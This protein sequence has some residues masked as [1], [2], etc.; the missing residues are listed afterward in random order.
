MFN[1][2]SWALRRPVT[3]ITLAVGL[4]LLG[5]VAARRMRVDIFPNLNLPVVYV[6]QPYGGMDPSQMEGLLTNYYEYHFLYINGIHHVESR[7]VQG[8]A[9]MKL[10]FHPGTDMA[11]AM[12]ETLGYVTRARAFM[13]PGT[14][15]PFV[16]RFDAGSIPVGYL[17]LSSET[18]T[19]NEIQ[20]IALFKV[21]PMFAG[22]PGV[23]AP[24]PFGGSQRTIV[25]QLDPDRLKSYRMAPDE[26]IK[27]LNSGNTISPSGTVRFGNTMPIVPVNALARTLDDFRQ[28][29]V[30]PGQLPT[31]HLGDVANVA[32]AADVP[33]G[34]AL[35]NGRKAVYLLVT[36]RADSSTLDVVNNVKNAL[37]EM[38]A[39]LPNDIKVSLEFDQSPTVTNAVRAVISEAIL[40]ALLVGLMVLLFLRDWR[41]ML[42]V[43]I[44]IPLALAGAIFLLWISGQSFNLMTLGGL[45]LAIGILVDES[46]VELENI[47]TQLRQT[48]S[49][50]VA[51]RR[52]NRETAVPR[53]LALLCMLAVFAPSF[54]MTGAIRALFV[55]LSMAVGYAM[56][57]SYLLSS[58]LVPVL[59]AY[60]MKP[61]GHTLG[62]ADFN[63]NPASDSPAPRPRLI[64]SFGLLTAYLA[65]AAF[66]IWKIVPRAGFEVF[67]QADSGRFQVRV[68]APA[69]TRFE[70]TE[71]IVVDVVNSVKKI[72]GDEGVEVSVGYVGNIGSSYPIQ[73]I[74]QW[75]GGP[76]EAF[77]RVALDPSRSKYSADQTKDLLRQELANLHPAVSF[78]FEPADIVSEVMSFGSPTPVEVV[79]TGSA[80]PDV[81]AYAAK[82]REELA[83]VN[84]IKDLRY[85]QTLDYPALRVDIDRR[86]AG[87]SG[88][89]AG[90]VARS[91]VTATSSSRFIMPS[92]W[93]DPKSGIGY[94]VQVEIPYASITSAEELA[95]LPINAGTDASPVVLRDVATVTPDQVPGEFDRYN[96]KRTVSLTANVATADLSIVSRDVAAAVKAAGQ[97]PT[98]VTVAVRGQLATLDELNKAGSLALLSTFVVIFLLLT[99][100]YQSSGLAMVALSGIPAV[101]LGITLALVLTSTTWNLQS[102]MGAIMALGVSVANAIILVSFAESQRLAGMDVVSAANSALRRRLRPILMTAL[103]MIAG[104]LPMALGLSEGGQQQAPLG[105]AVIGGL[106]GSLV[107]VVLVM[108]R[109]FAMIRARASHNNRSLDPADPNSPYY[110]PT[111][112]NPSQE[113]GSPMKN[114]LMAISLVLLYF[115]L[116]A[117]CVQAQDATAKA[118]APPKVSFVRAKPALIEHKI[119]QPGQVE[120]ALAAQIQS[121]AA[122]W[123]KTVHVDIGD[124]VKKGQKLIEI[125]APE[126]QAE[127]AISRAQIDEASAQVELAKSQYDEGV[128]TLKADQARLL[129]SNADLKG[130]QAILQQFQ[131]ELDRIK[132]LVNS[133]AVTRSNLEEAEQKY[134]SASA[135]LNESAAMESAARA[136]TDAVKAQL[137]RRKAD[138]SVAQARL[139]VA[140]AKAAETQARHDFMTIKAP[141][142]G[143]IV[144]RNTDPGQ[145]VGSSPTTLPLL[146]IH[147]LDL[148]T[149]TV[150]VPEAEAPL[151]DLGDT[152]EIYTSQNSAKPA[153]TGK[154]SRT[155]RAYN[156]ATRTLR[157]EIDVPAGQS[158]LNSGQYVLVRVIGHSVQEPVT[159]PVNAIYKVA[160]N[161]FCTIVSSGTA[162]RA[163]VSVGV[164]DGT[165]I[166]ISSGVKS[167]DMVIVGPAAA[168]LADGQ[169][170]DASELDETKK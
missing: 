110:D 114:P 56:M 11:Q 95:N 111:V 149:V 13:P 82:L 80:L 146:L 14:V 94:Q 157:T 128:E 117:Q 113:N 39:V 2:I 25:V 154:I 75:T 101:G 10:Y 118:S 115:P 27:A 120:P 46:T 47:H 42:I 57:C 52:G 40:G 34:S 103:A 31:I 16:T 90:D 58:T 38:Q 127:L 161:S 67:P 71:K 144:E 141:F 24:P 61:A 81:R 72:V 97:P 77:L 143:V 83:K 122:G 85:G 121:R 91:L 6:C 151:I 148:L 88:L 29:P 166:A 126:L 93:P 150:G 9:L 162:R 102:Y 140:Q 18:R 139:A 100:Y 147:K 55:P 12:A 32:D 49:V 1:P 66:G 73:A 43:I 37:P 105:R 44:N 134:L 167:G 86:R 70:V 54:L 99:A 74:F 62:Q 87:L 78:S 125:D 112:D 76:E 158:R 138:I 21:R 28:I 30:R 131:L 8:L 3:V 7:N 106:V 160:G 68:K 98:G 50:P 108:P 84:S 60:L 89:T 51:V 164:G 169:A 156:P 17:V 64:L 159:L 130:K 135:E 15:S 133:G 163:G 19:I 59:A 69:G 123:V 152:V 48:A 41:G 116:S 53:L 33:V 23:S 132:R 119:E 22:L 142:D 20:D 145:I 165:R 65:V 63:T 45:A 35:V 137:A 155:S 36:K 170:V 5:T 26:V 96:M 104:M 4:M 92:Y 168:T 124:L 129:A 136:Q 153:F 79:A 107:A 109:V